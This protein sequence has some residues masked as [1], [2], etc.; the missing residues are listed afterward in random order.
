MKNALLTCCVVL[1]LA[2][3]VLVTDSAADPESAD[4]HNKCEYRY[5]RGITHY[6]EVQRHNHRG[7]YIQRV[8]VYGPV[9]TQ[10][11]GISHSHWY[12]RVGCGLAG[13]VVGG[14]V[15]Y[16]TG[17]NPYYSGSAAVIVYEVCM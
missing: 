17:G 14:I 5:V 7:P 8:P 1:A 2:A 6:E 9:W 11:C 10:V 4:A 16:G 12:Q 15:A 3:A 13:V